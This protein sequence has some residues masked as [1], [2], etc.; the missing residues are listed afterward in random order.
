MSPRPEATHRGVPGCASRARC[1]HSLTR[2]SARP[3]PLPGAVP[4]SLSTLWVT[5]CSSQPLPHLGVSP[6]TA[7]ATEQ[8][9]KWG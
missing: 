8:V 4:S 7:L 9:P 1:Q 5:S 2:L 6:I 3:E